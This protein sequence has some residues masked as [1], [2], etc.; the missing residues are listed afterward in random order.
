MR[1]DLMAEQVD[2]ATRERETGPAMPTRT[3]PNAA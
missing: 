1:V 2:H 3:D